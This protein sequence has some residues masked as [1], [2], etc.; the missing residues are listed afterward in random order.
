MRI[1]THTQ[2]HAATQK[3]AWCAPVMTSDVFA[4]AK[5]CTKIRPV[6]GTGGPFSGGSF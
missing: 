3:L 4:S 5:A 2:N 1:I 6:V